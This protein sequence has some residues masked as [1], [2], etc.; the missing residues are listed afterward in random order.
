YSVPDAVAKVLEKKVEELKENINMFEEQSNEDDVKKEVL[1]IE[2]SDSEEIDEVL[3]KRETVTEE[4]GSFSTNL[5]QTITADFGVQAT[6]K[7]EI[8]NHYKEDN[9]LDMS[10]DCPDCGSSLQFAE[11]CI[12][13]RSCGFSKCG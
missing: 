11:G 2:V 8:D 5:N 12:L 7:A 10:P 4:I 1:E 3:D 6:P 13:C 9:E